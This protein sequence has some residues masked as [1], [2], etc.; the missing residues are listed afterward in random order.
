MLISLV[1]IRILIE[2]EPKNSIFLKQKGKKIKKYIYIKETFDTS[3]SNVKG[4]IC[5][6]KSS[7]HATRI[8]KS[9]FHFIFLDPSSNLI[10]SQVNLLLKTIISGTQY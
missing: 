9:L 7:I 6:T 2:L 4:L 10:H 3:I 5:Y 8:L 1:P